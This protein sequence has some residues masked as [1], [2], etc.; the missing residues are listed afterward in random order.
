ML[1]FRYIESVTMQYQAEILIP[2]FAILSGVAI[3][4]FCIHLAVLRREGQKR[5]SLGNCQAPRR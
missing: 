1:R 3:P 5:N 4:Y 2:L